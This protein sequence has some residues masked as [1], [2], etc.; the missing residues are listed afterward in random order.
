MAV[1][2]VDSCVI[3]DLG[4]P[5]SEWFEWSAGALER[6]DENH[7]FAINP[8]IYSECSVGYDTVEETER[9]FETLAFD[10]LEIPR[11]ALFLAGK[12]FLEY[13]RRRGV[14]TG[15]LPDF[16][17]GAHAAVEQYPLLTRDRSRF[18]SYFPT[19]ELIAPR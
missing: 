11:E 18:A 5:D 10:Y 13:R 1:V 12:A 19:V 9:L 6:L 3:T 2:L 8:I 7:A 4:N 14:K 17:I 16:F 15:A